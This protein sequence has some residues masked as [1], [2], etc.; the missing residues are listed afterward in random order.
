MRA[1]S[2]LAAQ[3]RL[4]QEG[5]NARRS[6]D[7]SRALSLF[8]ELLSRYP[9]SPLS[10][11]ARVERFRALFH[12]GR[13][14]EAAREARRYLAFYPQGFAKEEARRLV[15]RTGERNLD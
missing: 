15:L 1:A 5:M 6:G 14:E 7:A 11:N 2:S 8:G 10:E 3:N 4:F 12:L 13:I 9:K